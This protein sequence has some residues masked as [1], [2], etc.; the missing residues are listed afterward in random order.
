MII[1]G[2]AEAQKLKEQIKQEILE[3]DL[4]LKLVVVIV[5]DDPASQIYVRN[6]K[7]ACEGVGIQSEIV[8]LEKDVT[9]SVLN[10]TLDSL[11]NDV[12]VNGI[13]LQLPL[14]RHLNEDQALSHI[15]SLKD[16]DGLTLE[17][18]GKLF[19]NQ[20]TIAPCTPLGI[21]HLIKTVCPN[22]KGLNAVVVGRS[23]LVGK[24]TAQLLLN[25][26][27]TVTICHSKTK[28]LKEQTL[29]ADILVVAIG[30]PKFITGEYI[31][32]DA[33]VIDVG[34]NR[35]EGKIVGDV[36]FESASEIASHITPVPKGVGPMT[37]AMLLKNL[38]TLF[39]LQQKQIS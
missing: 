1:D 28:N 6:K 27:C 39:E 25:S 8:A 14:P 12:S 13:L 15:D 23:A 36:D 32:K 29:L 30:Q 19:L 35:V 10:Q 11:S 16:V 17:N 37:V 3:K 4:K 21:L 26:D 22:L 2:K 33:I 38:L 7:L 18:A 34:I 9:Q 31:K 24:P 20:N 5:G